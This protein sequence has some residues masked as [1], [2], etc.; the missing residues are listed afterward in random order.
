MSRP[1]VVIAG[2]ASMK[3][4][5]AADDPRR[6][7]ELVRGVRDQI[8]IGLVNDKA[9]A[10]ATELFHRAALELMYEQHRAR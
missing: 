4:S 7:W 2:L 8:R 9:K 6:F 1:T 3:P 5:Y 10:D